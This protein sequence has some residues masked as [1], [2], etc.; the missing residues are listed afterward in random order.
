MSSTVV[1][2]PQE[3]KNTWNVY[4][5]YCDDERWDLDSYVRIHELNDVPQSVLLF[6]EI[7]F[8]VLKKGIVFI[9]KNKIS[10]T[11]ED[12]HNRDGGCLSY[13]IPFKIMTS[14]WRKIFFSFC[15]W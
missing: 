9:M 6:E 3:L 15:S 14:A 1:S 7:P 4:F 10:P 5:H 8:D 12:K 11:W 13:R 2:I